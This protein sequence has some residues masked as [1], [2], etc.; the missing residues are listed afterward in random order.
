MDSKFYEPIK[1][2]LRK[3]CCHCTKLSEPIFKFINTHNYFDV[4]G[5]YCIKC[6]HL[7]LKN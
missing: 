7:I 3:K 4:K 5:P 6:T 1:L 2:P